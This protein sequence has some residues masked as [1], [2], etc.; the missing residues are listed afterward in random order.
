MEQSLGVRVPS[1]AVRGEAAWKIDLPKL[2]DPAQSGPI[3]LASEHIEFEKGF[4]Q[5]VQ[6]EDNAA[7]SKRGRFPAGT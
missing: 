4:P 3:V 6:H 2:F 1:L 5:E 7:R